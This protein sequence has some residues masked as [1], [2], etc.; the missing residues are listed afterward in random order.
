MAFRRTC[1][2][3][4]CSGSFA[5]RPAVRQW[6]MAWASGWRAPSSRCTTPPSS[7]RTPSRAC[8]RR[9]HWRGWI[10]PLI[11]AT[12]P[13]TRLSG[14][15][16]L[17]ARLG[18]LGALAGASADVHHGPAPSGQIVRVA[19]LGHLQRFFQCTAEVLLAYFS[20]DATAQEIRPEKLGKRDGFLC[21][22]AQP[23]ELT[24]KGSERIIAQALDGTRQFGVRAT[25]AAFIEGMQPPA[26]VHHEPEG[27]G[28]ELA[29]IRDDQGQDA[30]DAFIVQSPRQM[31][32]IDQVGASL[33]T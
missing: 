1:G 15:G 17:P 22:A 9:C 33:R 21:E 18:R 7:C 10:D 6:A 31:M 29:Q 13:K 8:A 32:V 14:E 3:R 12:D 23:P 24:G 20:F 16:M 28:V 19:G 4:C 27:G 30:L 26:I 5:S 25:A 2:E 11:S